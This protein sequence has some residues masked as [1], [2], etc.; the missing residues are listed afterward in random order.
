[1][2]L[3]AGHVLE[4]SLAALYPLATL[5]I[6]SGRVAI[7][8]YFFLQAVYLTIEFHVELHGG[9]VVEI[10]RPYKDSADDQHRYV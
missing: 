7:E 8:S 1:M 10:K 5:A 2:E 4:I 9:F 3:F 6:L